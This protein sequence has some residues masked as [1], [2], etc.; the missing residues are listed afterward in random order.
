MPANLYQPDN[1]PTID[2]GRYDELPSKRVM[3]VDVAALQ[4]KHNVLNQHPIR[5][6]TGTFAC[7]RAARPDQYLKVRNKA[8]ERFV[9]AMER[10]GWELYGRIGVYQSTFPVTEPGGIVIQ[11]DK[12]EYTIKAMFRHLHQR[13]MRV[14]I[15]PHL[16]RRA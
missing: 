16:I 2:W 3:G 9:R 12:Q 4:A 5:W 8:I 1:L 7:P 11:Y 14:E 13:P 10:K 15:P 6:L